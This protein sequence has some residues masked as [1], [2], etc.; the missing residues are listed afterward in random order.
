LK[1]KELI[2]ILQE[3]EPESQV[4]LSSD[5][6]GNSFSP[7]YGI[8]EGVF[9]ENG[10]YEV[11]VLFKDETGPATYDDLPDKAVVLFPRG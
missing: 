5:G 9:Y 7:F 1:V 8:D 11:D 4:F 10:V 2:M 3:C 6:E